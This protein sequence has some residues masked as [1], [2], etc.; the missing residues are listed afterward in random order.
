MLPASKATLLRLMNQ[1]LPASKA[2]LLRLEA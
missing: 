1:M 2:T